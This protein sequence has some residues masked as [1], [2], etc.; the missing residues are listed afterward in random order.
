MQTEQQ[1]QERQIAGEDLT[2][3]NP[4]ERERRLEILIQRRKQQRWRRHQQTN[5]GAEGTSL[6]E[7]R[8]LKYFT[9]KWK[10]FLISLNI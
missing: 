3:K 8:M 6:N 9:S 7:C 10:R 5:S 2:P 1:T 4:L